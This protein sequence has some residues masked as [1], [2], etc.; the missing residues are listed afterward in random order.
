MGRDVDDLL[1]MVRNSRDRV[2]VCAENIVDSMVH[3]TYNATRNI[4]NTA[5]N[6]EHRVGDLHEKVN[7]MILQQRDFAQTL[8]SVHGKNSLLS[9]LNEYISKSRPTQLDSQSC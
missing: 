8:E 4:D 7:E 5:N 2:Q 1:S 3:A 9:F 6:I